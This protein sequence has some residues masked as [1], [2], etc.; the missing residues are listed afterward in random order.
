MCFDALLQITAIHTRL[1]RALSYH[2]PIT[3]E[4]TGPII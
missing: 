4:T 2:L 1:A 3:F